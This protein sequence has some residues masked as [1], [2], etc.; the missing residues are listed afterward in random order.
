MMKGLHHIAVIVSDEAV[1][2]RFYEALGFRCVSRRERPQRQ[3]VIVM[4]EAAGITLEMFVQTGKPKRLSFPEAYGLRH[5]ALRYDCVEEMH[6]KLAAWNPEPLRTDDFTGEKM[7][8][9]MDPDGLPIEIH[10]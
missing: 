4:L 7:F 9:V 1:S 2:L 5:L 3:D 6:G 8:F 10:A